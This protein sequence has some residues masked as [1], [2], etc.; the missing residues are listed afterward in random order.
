MNEKLSKLID[1]I[2]E[3]FDE[4]LE[5]EKETITEDTSF[6]DVV[7]WDSIGALGVIVMLEDC[8]GVSVTGIQMKEELN[9]FRD[10]LNLIESSK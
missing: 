7:W 5:V 4:G 9:T 2:A 1:Q 3:T 10:L 6:K 8:Y